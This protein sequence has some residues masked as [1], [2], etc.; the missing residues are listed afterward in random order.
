LRVEERSHVRVDFLPESVDGKP[1]PEELRR[2][3]GASTLLVL[4]NV[5]E[6]RILEADLAG[7]EFVLEGPPQKATFH[8]RAVV[9]FQNTGNAHLQPSC[10]ITLVRVQEETPAE[11]AIAVKPGSSLTLVSKESPDLV[12]PGGEGMLVLE[13]QNTLEPGKYALTLVMVHQGKEILRREETLEL[14]PGR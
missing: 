10:S 11:G 9:R 1:V 8:P 14:R 5:K 3:F 4:E 13:S 2:A 7:I 12:L 6:T